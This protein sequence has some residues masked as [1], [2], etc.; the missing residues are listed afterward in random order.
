MPLKELFDETLDINA[1]QNYELTV[2]M[3]A[4]SLSFCILDGIRNK[5]IMFRSYVPDNHKKFT[6]DQLREIMYKDDFLGKSYRAIRAILPSSRFTMIP[7]A[8]YDPGKKEEY[9]GFN[10][11]A[12]ESSIILTDRLSDPDSWLLFSVFRPFSEIISEKWSLV[13]PQHHL[14]P[15]FC[16][17]NQERKHYSGFYIHA[18]IEPDFFNLLIFGENTLLLANSYQYRNATDIMYHILNAFRIIGIKQEET[19]VLSGHTDRFDDLSSNLMM[20][21]RNVKFINFSGSQTFSYVFNDIPVHR[22]I[23]LFSAGNCE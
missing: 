18:H 21:I 16:Q 3:E 1:T 6:P 4:H 8:L 5:F 19:I 2:E 9:F 14:R 17:V 22:Y 11:P 12:E 23:N 13:V 20:Y 15:L 7:T 10:H